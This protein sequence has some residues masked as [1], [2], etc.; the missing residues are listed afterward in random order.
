MTVCIGAICNKGEIGVVA[1]DRMVTSSFPPIEFEHT[2]K[3][4]LAITDYCV[5]S[6][7]GNALKSINIIPK[8]I[9]SLGKTPDIETIAQRTKDFYQMLRGDEAEALLLKP[10]TLN[11]EVFYTRG[12]SIFPP[13]LFNIIDHQFNQYDYGLEILLVGVD[14]GG[15]HLFSISN[16]G[17]LNCFDTLGF[18]AIGIGYL[19][20]IQ[21]FIAHG[22]KTSCNLEEAIN[23]VYAAKKADEVAP[24]VGTETDISFITES[25]TIDVDPIIIDQIEKIYDEVT[26]PKIEE[27][28]EKSA[29]LLDLLAKA[30]EVADNGRSENKEKEIS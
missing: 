5:T 12:A 13:D 29:R 27:L 3:K 9:T 2:R 11:K 7:A 22:Y 4:L 28:K 30:K 14:L 26:K 1:S 10:R 8:V 15:A 18:H 17:L 25:K 23:I 6:T 16:P 24:G 19:H 21:V 20:A